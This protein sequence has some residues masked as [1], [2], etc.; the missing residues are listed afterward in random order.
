LKQIFK[1][2]TL[3]GV[4]VPEY[5]NGADFEQDKTTELWSMSVKTYLK[6]VIDK[7]EGLLKVHLKNYESPMAPDEHPEEDDSELLLAR[8]VSIYQ[9][10]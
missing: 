5:Y 3:K 7:I 6:N 4:G 2:Y 10:L 8:E 9:M 1:K